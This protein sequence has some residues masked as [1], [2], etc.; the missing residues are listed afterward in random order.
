[1][2]P[3]VQRLEPPY[4]QIVEDIRRRIRSGQLRDGELIP[5]VRQLA[6][7]WKVS[8]PTAA[9]AVM[10]LRAEGLVQ[11]RPGVGTVVCAG[12]TTHHPGGE[13]LRAVRATG[14]IYPPGEHAV[15]KS[16]E[17]VAAPPEIADALGLEPGA[18]VIRRHRVTFREDVPISASVTWLDGRLAEVAPRLLSTERIIAGTIG[19]IAQATGRE[20]VRGTDQDSARAATEQDADDLGVPVGSPVACGR[21]WWYDANGVV[22]EYGERVSVPGRW[23]THEYIAS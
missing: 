1:M 5:S 23:S 14:R 21:N 7:D 13:R 3:D 17:L 19:Y 4:L 9:K 15:I 10:T 12:T 22:V 20:V 8:P 16:A 2:A 18:M 11:G 6:K